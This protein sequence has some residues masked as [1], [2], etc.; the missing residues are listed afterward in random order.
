MVTSGISAFNPAATF[1]ITSALRKLAVINEDEA[2]T[3][4][5]YKEGLFA[6]NALTKELEATGIHVWTEEE[7]IIFLQQ[8]QRRYN[9]GT[10]QAGSPAADRA[11]DANRWTFA[12]L[13]A[14][15]AA[16]ATVLTVSAIT[17][18]ASGD[19]FGAVLNTG[20]AFWTTLNGA[21][22]GNT[23]TLAAAL[24]S[25][26][27][28]QGCCFSY[29]VAAQ[30]IRPLRVPFTRRLQYAPSTALPGAIG[31][32]DWGGIITPLAPMMSRQEFFNLPQ[33]T[34]PGLV[35]QAFYDPARDQG[36]MWVWNVSQNA[37]SALRFTYYRPLQDW[38]TPATTADLPQEWSNCLIWMLADELK[39]DYSVSAQR[40]LMI[41]AK[42]KE[43]R[44]L[45][46][47]WD[48][49]PESVYFGRS[50]PQT[51]G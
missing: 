50:S 7:G 37:N 29:P 39:L 40:A 18:M 20:A 51:R 5:Q 26:V 16:G 24:P 28:A 13:S 25:A 48:R 11:C 30:I 6:L 14:G 41:E 21:P 9:L 32:P 4:G 43:K 19:H 49:E 10:G 33:P 1:I 42:A 17:G 47:G 8:Y 22:S 23:V 44:E 31:A 35:S 45:V 15:A 38:S 34:N 2:P 46:E 27:S 36:Q 12:T 3:A